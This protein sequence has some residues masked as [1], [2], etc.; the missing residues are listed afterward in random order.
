M[1]SLN[2]QFQRENFT[3]NADFVLDNPVTGLFGASGSGKSTLLSLIAGLEHPKKGWIKLDEQY[4]F[5]QQ[6]KIN[7]LP[8]KRQIG[9]V[10]QDSQLFPHLSVKQNLLFGYIRS[11]K[12]QRRFKLSEIVDLLEIGQ[13]LKKLPRN[14]QEEKNNALA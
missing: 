13:L 9:I 7:I 5:H 11:E 6:K 10:F 4:L 1:L 14:F 12:N 3:L 8:N 2:I